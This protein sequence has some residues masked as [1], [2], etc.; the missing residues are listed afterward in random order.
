MKKLVH[1]AAT[2]Y[3]EWFHGPS[4]TAA[5]CG[6][7]TKRE[8]AVTA[9]GR[10]QIVK[11]P[12]N[13]FDGV[14]YCLDCVGAMTITC[15]WCQQPIFIGDFVILLR[16]DEALRMP[17]EGATVYQDGESK[18]FVGCSSQLCLPEEGGKIARELMI[19]QGAI[20]LSPGYAHKIMPVSLEQMLKSGVFASSP[21]TVQIST[22]T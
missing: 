6:H 5:I 11:L 19:A 3:D 17:H 16:I 1:W 21:E 9:R 10:T 22:T 15:A 14:D 4:M 20:W 13:K 8:G 2:I 12:S 18:R 7:T